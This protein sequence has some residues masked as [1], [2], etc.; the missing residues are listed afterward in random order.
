MRMV[1]KYTFNQ[2][3]KKKE[4]LHNSRFAEIDCGY[5]THFTLS[6]DERLRKLQIGKTNSCL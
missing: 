5:C 1:K 6:P 4:N 2:K 3:S